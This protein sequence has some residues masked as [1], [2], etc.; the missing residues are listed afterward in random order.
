MTSVFLVEDSPLIRD[1]LRGML[2]EFPDISHAG[3]ATGASSAIEAILRLRPQVVLLDLG[4]AEG[5]GFDVLRAVRATAPEVDCYM[6]SHTS[7][8][9]YRQLAERLGARGFFDKAREFEQVRDML[10]G[11][12]G[13]TQH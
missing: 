4:L 1:R 13:S 6:L 3:E 10:A 11:L 9:P 8:Y 7:A 2:A 5:G 12:S